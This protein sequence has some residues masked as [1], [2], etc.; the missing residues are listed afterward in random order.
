MFDQASILERLGVFMIRDF[1]EPGFCRQIL[2][3]ARRTTLFRP[4]GITNPDGK[5]IID[6]SVR[7]VQETGLPKSIFDTVGQKLEAIKPQ[8]EA[9]FEVELVDRQGPHFLLYRKGDFFM[10]HGDQVYSGDGLNY[11][12]R[13]RVS[14]VIF[15]NGEHPTEDEEPA[16]AEIDCYEGGDLVFYGLLEREE[17]ARVGFSLNGRPGLF[18]AFDSTVIHEV[19]PVTAGDRL[20]IVA[21]FLGE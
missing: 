16:P 9:K 4:G 10:P 5:T 14:A 12:Q 2:E 7:K 20:T 1:M 13:R 3:E 11:A 21:W 15:V 19:K 17:M 6:E 8:L 18:A